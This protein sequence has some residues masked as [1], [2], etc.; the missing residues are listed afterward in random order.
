MMRR[1]AQFFLV[2]CV[3]LMP[4]VAQRGGGGFHGGMGGFHGGIGGFH[5]G[6]GG[7]HGGMGGFQGGGFHGG[8]VGPGFRGGFRGFHG[9]FRPGNRFGFGFGFPGYWPYYGGWG[10]P[11]SGYSYY[12]P[13]PVYSYPYAYSYP[14]V[15]G[16]ASRGSVQTSCPH[17]NGRAL[18]QIKLT[19]QNDVWLA[20]Q[21]WYTPGTLN[22]ITLQGE[23]KKTPIDSI[24]QGLTS[25]L[26]R[27]CGVN[28]QF[29]K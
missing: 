9:G 25:E 14:N 6:M 10:Y 23:E 27:D 7:F 3:L 13:Y 12:Y 22:F 5:G 20:Q 24:D 18:Y 2:A 11:Y 21:Y 28:F 17:V 29:A 4:A 16:Y 19:Y 15:E 8:F 26:N 1:F